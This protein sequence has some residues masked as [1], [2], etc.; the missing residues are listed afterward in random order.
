M[1]V[2]LISECEKKAWKSTRRIVSQYLPQHGSRVWMGSIDKE[3]LAELHKELRRKATKNNAIICFLITSR[4]TKTIAF[5]V[6]SQKMF[7]EQGHYAFSQ[8]RKIMVWEEEELPLFTYLALLSK[9]AGL[10]HDLGK[11]MRSFQ[12]KLRTGRKTDP[13]RHDIYSALLFLHF[14]DKQKAFNKK[15]TPEEKEKVVLTILSDPGILNSQQ[16]HDCFCDRARIQIKNKAKS[17]KKALHDCAY[18]RSVSILAF[19]ITSHHILPDIYI[20]RRNNISLNLTRYFHEKEWKEDPKTKI[21]FDDSCELP[22]QNK[23]WINKLSYI[24]ARILELQLDAVPYETLTT[25]AH[26][27]ARPALA[28]A[29]QTVSAEGNQRRY[30]GKGDNHMFANTTQDGEPAQLLIDHLF[31]VSRVAER[32][33]RAI[34]HIWQGTLVDNVSALPKTLRTNSSLP[35]LPG[36]KQ[37]KKRQNPWQ[38]SLRQAMD[39][40]VS[41]LRKRDPARP[42]QSQSS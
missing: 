12:Q 25:Y 1:N 32:N 17:L 22:W 33:V 38:T 28:A 30:P 16:L 4:L 3:G 26:L 29:D 18:G 27:I 7:D 8:T 2:L 36:S 39:F 13:I 9:A 10:L 23:R 41:C 14:I 37:L 15:A 6:G 35:V 20:E 21:G 24:F 34:R 19:L 11:T 40:S 5:R 42:V 31:N